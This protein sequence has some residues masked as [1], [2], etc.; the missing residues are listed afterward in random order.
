MKM[1]SSIQITKSEKHHNDGFQEKRI[2]SGRKSVKI[3]DN[4]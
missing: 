4:N 1:A 3:A 2:F